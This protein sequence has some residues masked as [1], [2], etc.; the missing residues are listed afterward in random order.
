VPVSWRVPEKVDVPAELVAAVES[1]A[2]AEVLY[3]RGFTTAAAAIDFLT[4]GIDV[5]APGLPD[6][7]AGVAVVLDAVLT[8]RR[9][10]VY[11]DYDTD[12]VTSTTLLVDLLRRLGA[13]V[14][15]YIPNRFKDGYGM[16]VR[17]VE[18]LADEGTH[19]LL[20]YLYSR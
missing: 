11:G 15:F 7:E 1:G 13:D 6:L 12:G 5:D 18:A 19:V 20:K 4:G 16:N 8:A 9:I 10:C 2:L 3:R 17:A 14:S